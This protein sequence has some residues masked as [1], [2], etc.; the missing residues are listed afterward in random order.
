VT[1]QILRALSKLSDRRQ[2]AGWWWSTTKTPSAAQDI[3]DISWRWQRGGTLVAQ[4]TA[5]QA[6]RC[7]TR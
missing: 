7:Q 2:H 4:G 5:A 3:S 1:N 6:G